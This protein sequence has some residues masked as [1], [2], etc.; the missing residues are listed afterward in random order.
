[1]TMLAPRAKGRGERETHRA[2]V[3]VGALQDVLP[4]LQ[5]LEFLFNRLEK[6]NKII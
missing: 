2:N 1:M 4:L 6:N 3:H 5:L